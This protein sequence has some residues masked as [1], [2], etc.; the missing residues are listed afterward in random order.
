LKSAVE[1][2]NRVAVR[3]DHPDGEGFR[4]FLVEAGKQCL[5]DLG[6]RGAE[7]SLLLVDDPSIRALN[8]LWRKKNAVTDV[9]SFPA[10]E[11]PVAIGAR[12][13][14]GDVA[15]SLDTARTRAHRGR[16]TVQQEL[17]RYLAHGILHLLG[18]DHRRTVEAKVMAALERRLLG[19]RGLIPKRH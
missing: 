16:I 15:L 1:R 2:G 6:V 13:P 8:R 11:M 7:L 19:S 9:L 4:R 18:Y 3:I 17:R 12:K 14:L 5:G 10:G